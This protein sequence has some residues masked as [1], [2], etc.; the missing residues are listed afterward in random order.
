M[1]IFNWIFLH[2]YVLYKA[3]RLRM[4]FTIKTKTYE[5]APVSQSFT[6]YQTLAV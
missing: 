2:V 4:F 1:L 6:Y 5:H 3:G